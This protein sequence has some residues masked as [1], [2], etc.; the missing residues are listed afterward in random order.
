[1][2][3]TEEN[4]MKH[5]WKKP[6]L[7]M[8]VTVTLAGCSL[9]SASTEDEQ[10][11]GNDPL[12]AGAVNTS[13]GGP[14]LTVNS[15]GDWNGGSADKGTLEATGVAKPKPKLPETKWDKEKPTLAGISLALLKTDVK[16]K[17]GNPA[18]SYSQEGDAGSIGICDYD[19][20]SIGFD[21]EQQGVLF[22]EVYSVNVAT[23]LNGVKVGDLEDIAVKALGKPDS[24]SSYLLTYKTTNS[25]LK[26]DLDPESHEILSIKLFK[27]A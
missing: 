5:V 13:N 16:A 19:G 25:L 24:Q 15:N 9:T 21:S 7:A 27:Q 18:D 10:V 6:A 2:E 26:L 17:L 22:I 23:G 8:F 11:V 14:N 1:L 20:L 4:L 3:R 12:A